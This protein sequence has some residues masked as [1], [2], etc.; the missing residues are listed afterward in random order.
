VNGHDWFEH[1]DYTFK[2]KALDTYVVHRTC[3][4]CGTT[5]TAI[6]QPK[7]GEVVLVSDLIWVPREEALK[8]MSYEEWSPAP[9]NTSLDNLEKTFQIYQY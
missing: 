6:P 5:E 7:Q 3:T 4:K 9:N 1:V 2:Y 8:R